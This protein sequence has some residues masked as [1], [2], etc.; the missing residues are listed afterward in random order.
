MTKEIY[1]TERQ[2]YPLSGAVVEQKKNTETQ[3][4]GFH[5][6]RPDRIDL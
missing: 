4:G 6:G 5:C 2:T 3:A 1:A